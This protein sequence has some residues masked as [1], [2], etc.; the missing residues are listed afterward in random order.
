MKKFICVLLSL[1]L[2]VSLFGCSS[3]ETV[4]NTSSVSQTASAS[5]EVTKNEQSTQK[6]SITSA[7]AVSNKTETTKKSDK[8]V[9]TESTSATEKSTQQK[10]KA[11]KKHTTVKAETTKKST[12][13]T[14]TTA[15]KTTVK[16]TNSTIP[17]SIT[18]TVSIDCSSV[19]DN[20]D[21][22]KQGHETFVPHDGIIMNT[23]SVTVS[24]TATVYDAVK[25]AC[26]KNGVTMNVSSSGF[27]KYIAGFNN[28]DEK[29]CGAAS[30]WKYKVNGTYP[31]KSC[32]KYKLNNGDSIVFLYTC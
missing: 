17:K 29:D 22:L 20:M 9:S 11:T 4:Q 6:N 14:N 32:D 25:L 24:G 23:T 2:C 10:S 12:V 21:N 19:L 28:I 7:S 5:N 8:S 16:T 31:S 18:C 15:K 26:D 1:F 3:K 30:G 27:G 13:K